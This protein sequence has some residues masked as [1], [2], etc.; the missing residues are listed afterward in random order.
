MTPQDIEH[1]DIKNKLRQQ[2]VDKE[3]QRLRSVNKRQSTKITN[4]RKALYF[5]LFF[6]V[7]LISIFLLKGMINFTGSDSDDEFEAFKLK[8]NDL[9]KV[10]KN[11]DDSLVQMQNTLEY[12]VDKNTTERG[13]DGLKFRVQIG[14]FKEIDLKDFKNNLVSINQETY[15]SINQY[16][17]GVFRDYQKALLFLGDI[18]NMGFDDSFIISTKNGRR[19]QLKDLSKEELGIESEDL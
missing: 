7:S 13:E 18:K 19:I 2:A 3:V 11:L 17:V 10:N 9:V 15:D 16:T 1:Q 5:Q 12:L 8:Y 6:F 4:L 14:A